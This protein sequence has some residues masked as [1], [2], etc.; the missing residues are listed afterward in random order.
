[1]VTGWLTPM[2]RDKLCIPADFAPAL[3]SLIF[4]SPCRRATVN[5]PASGTFRATDTAKCP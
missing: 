1:M 4:N 2:S 3:A 5:A